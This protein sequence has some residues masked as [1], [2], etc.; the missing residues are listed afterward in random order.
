MRHQFVLAIACLLVSI[1]SASPQDK[2]DPLPQ[3]SFVG[4]W[5][6]DNKEEIG[7]ILA[8]FVVSNK[9]DDWSIKAWFNNGAGK[10]AE[11]DKVK[12]S[13]LGDPGSSKSRPYGFA[14]WKLKGEKGAGDMTIHMTLRSEK[15]KPV[16]ETF[17]IIE[18]GKQ[19]VPNIRTLEKYKKK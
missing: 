2:A 9:D 5:I 16:V 6:G 1:P 15:E 11:M 7:G 4:E 10:F 14:T 18:G 12:L 3:D 13:L 19:T 8:R 17:M